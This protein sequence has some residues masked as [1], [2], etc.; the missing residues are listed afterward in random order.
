MRGHAIN[1]LGK[2]EKNSKVKEGDCIF[3]FKYKKK[4][5]K[6]GECADRDGLTTFGKI[7]ATSVTPR[8]TL[9][10]YGYCEKYTLKKKTAKTS[11]VK[12]ALVIKKKKTLKLK[13]KKPQLLKTE[14]KK[15]DIEQTMDTT[16]MQE[17]PRRLN[18]EFIDVLEQL[19]TIMTKKK[20]PFR[21]R[22]YIKA[23]EAIMN[24]SNDITNVNQLNGIK[25][26]GS[27]IVKK[28]KEY[29]DTGKIALL[30]KEKNDPVNLLMN[31]Y[32]IGPKKAEKLVA[33]GITTIAQLKEANKKDPELLTRNM[34]QGLE[35]YDDIMQRIPRD[36]IVKFDKVFETTFNNV[37]YP[38]SRMQI[39]GSYRRGKLNSGDID[40]IIT[41]K[42]NQK[43][44]F[45]A[46]INKLIQDKVIVEVLT[47][48]PVKSLTIAKIPD[49]SIARRV[50]FLY[51]PP[52]EFA[53]ALLYFTG[54]KTFNT[55]QRQRA[56]DLGYS[57]NEHGLY[58][59][60]NKK[61]GDRLDQEFLTERS[62]F[63]FL[64]M[65]YIPP[66]DRIDGRNI[67]YT[68]AA[69]EPEPEP[70]AVHSK[71]RKKLKIR[72]LK[73]KKQK[74]LESS[75]HI[76]SFK[77]EGLGILKQLTEK[78]LSKMIRDANDAYYCNKT[79]ILTDNQY[80]ILRE[81]TLEKYPDNV[82]AK[83][84]HTKCD[85]EVEKNKVK[86]PYEMWSMD[87][88]KPDTKYLSRWI[89]KYSGPYVLSC[90]LDGVSGMYST[91]GAEPKLYTRGDGITG[92]DVSHLIP[93]LKLPK[94]ENIVIRGEFIMPKKVFESKYSTQFSNARNFVAG[95][96]NQKKIEPAKFSDI[97][98]V[99]YEVIVPESTPSQQ[100]AYLSELSDVEVVQ[101]SIVSEISNES[102][103]NLLVKWRKTYKYEIDGVIC[104]DDKIYPR[105]HKNPEHAF[106]F[107]MVL[108]DQIAEAKVLDVIWTASKDGFLKPRVQIEPVTLGGVKIEYATGFNAKF[109]ED[110]K[111]GVGALIKLVR[112]GDVIPHIVEV[113]QP[114]SQAQ[115]P[116]VPYL[117][118]ETHVDIYL[119]NAQDDAGVKEKQITQFF[120]TIGV[121]GVGPGNVRKMIAIG[122]DSI[123]K[124][125]QQSQEE[126]K[127]NLLQVDGFKEKTAEKISR[128]IQERLAVV[129]LPV[130]MHA[131]NIFSSPDEQDKGA[132]SSLGR[133]KFA[134]I[135]K[136]SPSI[137]VSNDSVKEK[138]ATVEQ[139]DGMG[140][141]TAE[142]FV[143]KIPAFIEWMRKSNLMNK[144]KKS[145]DAPV[146]AAPIVKDTSH[147]LYKKKVVLTGTRD[148]KI[149]EKLEEVGAELQTTPSST[150]YLV[151]AKDPTAMTGKIKKA[152][153]AGVP[154]DRIINPEQLLKRYFS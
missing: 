47:R 45:D 48:G 88:I 124:I 151:V 3:P 78:A 123:P 65:E 107:K 18:E 109:I 98:F 25:N 75:D 39:V 53:F 154:D 126:L 136:H 19:G 140:K 38:T 110:N 108:S 36:E 84:G 100:M 1:K 9:K 114:A 64:K 89:Q 145:A 59:M 101:H 72:T 62:I 83:E 26:I 111:I 42:N 146:E 16:S 102:L 153:E 147:E 10:T 23:A 37:A 30:E 35:Y 93:Y 77:K 46:F 8:K 69:P 61:K 15:E 27:S 68:D 144:L 29:V 142:K 105:A 70:K 90:K 33:K 54:S 60:V 52:E 85:L 139:V 7:C 130:L 57:L 50:D 129:S 97:D 80:D 40:L 120:K 113:I 11:T 21:A 86:L 132:K 63:D 141:K 135:L 73:K 2:R 125:L 71:K 103:S 58:K 34:K 152:K 121:E 20:E 137:I 4:L 134:A 17:P 56:L 143:R 118:N 95:V 82:A 128:G 5:Y 112:S 41:D 76:D 13:S 31:V 24:H 66:T 6:N 51:A 12:K 14:T 94:T 79:P 150:T 67:V 133:K 22:A 91:E 44:V 148:K 115:M 28:L 43:F 117:W 81:Y 32:G 74:T 104:I 92:Q 106:A 119:K 138:I 55:I 127:S 131:S 149:I 99:A 49:S 87:K 96:V 116:T 122:Y